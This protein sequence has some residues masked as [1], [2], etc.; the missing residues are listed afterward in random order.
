V[1]QRGAL[2]PDT[3]LSG[4]FEPTRAT[5]DLASVMRE[6]EDALAEERER[7]MRMP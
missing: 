6:V 1:Y 5:V 4:T 2:R 7:R 3:V